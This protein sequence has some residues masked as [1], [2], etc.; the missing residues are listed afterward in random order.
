MQIKTAKGKG[1]GCVPTSC[2]ASPGCDEKKRKVRS[3][4]GVEEHSHQKDIQRDEER[5]RGPRE[6]GQQTLMS[7]SLIREV[8]PYSSSRAVDL[9][10][11]LIWRVI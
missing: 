5:E 8:P 9:R 2:S 11:L 3:G 7:S 6:R 4:L 10:M 1:V